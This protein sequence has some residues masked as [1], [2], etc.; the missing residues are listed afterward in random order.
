V[1]W[2]VRVVTTGPNKY[3]RNRTQ[4]VCNRF[5]VPDHGFQPD[6]R[7]RRERIPRT[8]CSEATKELALE[9]EPDMTGFDPTIGSQKGQAQSDPCKHL[10]H[11]EYVQRVGCD[12]DEGQKV[13]SGDPE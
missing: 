5:E 3:N 13:L 2:R 11:W 12:L 9:T 4:Q 10:A 6:R 7:A 8:N 1:E